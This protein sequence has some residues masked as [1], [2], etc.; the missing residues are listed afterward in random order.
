[1]K[2]PP[3]LM[4][5][6]SHANSD[7]DYSKQAT[8]WRDTVAQRAEGYKHIVGLMLESNLVAGSQKLTSDL[9]QLKYGISITDGCIG[10]DQTEELLRDAHAALKR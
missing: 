3:Y 10:W 5:D 7:K 9:S 8:V 1:M 4:V 6:C 2:L